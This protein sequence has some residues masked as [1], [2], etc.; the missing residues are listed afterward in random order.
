MM[1]LVVFSLVCILQ[2]QVFGYG[3]YISHLV[4]NTGDRVILWCTNHDLSQLQGK[5]TLTWEKSHKTI[6]AGD[7]RLNTV[8][9]GTLELNNVQTEDW[10][11]Y[12]CTVTANNFKVVNTT[13]LIVRE[14]YQYR[15]HTFNRMSHLQT[16]LDVDFSQYGSSVLFPGSV[17]TN[18]PTNV[19]VV[20]AYKT[21]HKVLRLE[22]EASSNEQEK[23]PDTSSIVS[24]KII[25][26]PT[27]PLRTPFKLVFDHSNKVQEI[28]VVS[29]GSSMVHPCC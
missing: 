5:V 17:F 27:S 12:R 24:A 28:K 10:G 14:T 9:N 3:S 22:R 2:H 4:V 6:Q 25:P 1:M 16:Q 20:V 23:R 7:P 18:S 29:V 26:R 13:Y 11:F 21:V 19:A 8:A 15:Y